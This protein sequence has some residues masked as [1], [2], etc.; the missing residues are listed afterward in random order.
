MRRRELPSADEQRAVRRAG[1]P[2]Y[3]SSC[4]KQKRRS[5]RDTSENALNGT[6]QPVGRRPSHMSGIDLLGQP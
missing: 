4:D 1:E 3:R 6:C 5:R 2:A